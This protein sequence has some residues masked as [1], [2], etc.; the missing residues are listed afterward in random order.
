MV[1]LLYLYLPATEASDNPVV[2]VGW[3][4]KVERD[5]VPMT[6]EVLEDFHDGGEE[7][8]KSSHA[9]GNASINLL[10]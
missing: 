6:L 9:T 8:R 5:L 2:L 4:K 7:D 3:V 10:F 1:K